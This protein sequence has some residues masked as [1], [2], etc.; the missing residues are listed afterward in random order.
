[1]TCDELAAL[2]NAGNL[3]GDR[4]NICDQ[5]NNAVVLSVIAAVSLL[6]DCK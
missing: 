2:S 1:M 6:N 4:L 3:R 5:N